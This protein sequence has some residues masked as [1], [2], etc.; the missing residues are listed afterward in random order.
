MNRTLKEISFSCNPMVNLLLHVVC[1]F[2]SS[3]PR[4]PVYEEKAQEWLLPE[5]K[6]F[7]EQNF[8]LEQ[9]GKVSSTANFALLFQI[10]AYF[11]SSTLGSLRDVFEL[12]K[13]GKLDVLKDHFPEKKAFLNA[14]MPEKFQRSFFEESMKR[15][16]NLDETI[17]IYRSILESVYE[18][19]YRDYWRS[20][21]LEMERKAKSLNEL[22][23][24]KYSVIALW[25]SK[26]RLKYPYPKF[27]VELADPIATLGT[28]LMAER[29]AFSYW[30]TPERIF[31]IISHE[32]RTHTIIQ[33]NS[34]RSSALAILF[35]EDSERTLRVVEALAYLTNLAIWR[36]EKVDLEYGRFG[37]FFKKETEALQVNWND[38]EL[39]RISYID[40]VVKAHETLYGPSIN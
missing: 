23:F 39:G 38:Y 16:K 28:S 27:V 1:C 40:L 11:C 6:R 37:E 8:R 19:F 29:D 31:T 24:E 9:T 4:N 12:M 10:P 21:L 18:R 30:L 22:Y 36:D 14:Y 13:G 2:D 7:F 5:E 33:A 32:V 25:E 17:D 34:L 35:E 15:F 20:I 26:T 3:F